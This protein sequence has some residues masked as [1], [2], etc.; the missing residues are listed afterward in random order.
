MQAFENEADT[1]EADILNSLDLKSSRPLTNV[2]EPKYFKI[3]KEEIFAGIIPPTMLG[4]SSLTTGL[5]ASNPV[6]FT[7]PISNPVE[8][9][10][11]I[12]NPIDITEPKS[13]LVNFTETISSPA[14]LTEPTSNPVDISKPKEFGTY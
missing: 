4:A 5:V 6:D 3:S 12:S 9:T 10:E 11:P 13:N 1:N 14:D 2:I 8:I 7:E